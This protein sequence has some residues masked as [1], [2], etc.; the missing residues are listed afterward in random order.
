MMTKSSVSLL[1]LVLSTFGCAID[2]SEEGSVE[3]GLSGGMQ[4]AQIDP[5]APSPADVA[6]EAAALDTF[7]DVAPEGPA[8]APGSRVDDVAPG[9][10]GAKPGSRFDDVAPGAPEAELG[11]EFDDVEPWAPGAEPGS[12]FDDVAPEAPEAPGA[13]VGTEVDVASAPSKTKPGS[14]HTSAPGACVFVDPST[15][16]VFFGLCGSAK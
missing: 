12:E 4:V 8:A 3:S 14:A 13:A 2:S 9:A 7:D 10:P 6:A 16:A 1:V 5:L 11:S 15:G